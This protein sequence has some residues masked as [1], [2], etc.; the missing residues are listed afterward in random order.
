MIFLKNPKNRQIFGLLL[1]EYCSSRTFK[2]LVTLLSNF[3]V[4]LSLCPPRKSWR[5]HFREITLSSFQIDLH[6]SVTRFGKIS[7]FGNI[8]KT[9]ANYVWADSVFGKI[10]TC[11]GHHFMTWCKFSLLDCGL[12]LTKKSS[13]LVTLPHTNTFCFYSIYIP[14]FNQHDCSLVHLT[15]L[16]TASH[17]SIPS[18]TYLYHCLPI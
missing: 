16:P 14:V 13:H 6:T 3:S 7:H 4:S 10:W 18:S 15:Q 8:L 1:H 5:Y 17:L 9:Q 11:F 2:N 12:M